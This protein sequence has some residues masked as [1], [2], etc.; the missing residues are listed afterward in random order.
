M[1]TPSLHTAGANLP[2]TSHGRWRLS[3]AWFCR[4]RVAGSILWVAG[5]ANPA[6]PADCSRRRMAFDKL[7][8]PAEKSRWRNGWLR[9]DSRGDPAMIVPLPRAPGHG[10]QRSRCDCLH[11]SEGCLH[12]CRADAPVSALHVPARKG[13]AEGRAFAG[14]GLELDTGVEQLTQPLHDRQADPFAVRPRR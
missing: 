11:G 5:T 13:H 3:A 4:S 10:A 14:L 9:L 2:S 6:A 1:C 7:D 8:Q 12:G